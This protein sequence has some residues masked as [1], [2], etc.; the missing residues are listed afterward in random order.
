MHSIVLIL[1]YDCST[2]STCGKLLLPIRQAASLEF[3]CP[4]VSSVQCGRM[5]QKLNIKQ[6][7]PQNVQISGFGSQLQ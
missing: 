4:H 1:S 3:K 7:P 5:K 6:V 2:Y